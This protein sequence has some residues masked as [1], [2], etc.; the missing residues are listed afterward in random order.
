MNIIRRLFKRKNK[1]IDDISDVL[2]ETIVY[3]GKTWGLRLKKED[4][5][6]VCRY[7]TRIHKFMSTKAS[8]VEVVPK[9]N[10]GYSYFE[11][12][13][14]RKIEDAMRGMVRLLSYYKIQGYGV[15]KSVPIKSTT[16]VS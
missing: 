14:K 13:P 8:S 7:V 6:W 9:T 15:E 10:K 12:K 3:K 4:N 2:P 5:M 1:T 11:S 16:V